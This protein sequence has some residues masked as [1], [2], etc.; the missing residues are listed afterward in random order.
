MNVVRPVGAERM[1]GE[2]RKKKQDASDT[3]DDAISRSK[4]T[5]SSV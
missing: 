5:D 3:Y 2:N 1:E 4:A